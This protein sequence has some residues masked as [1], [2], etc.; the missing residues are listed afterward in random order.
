MVINNGMVVGWAGR[1]QINKDV[2]VYKVY[3]V[4]KDVTVAIFPQ[5]C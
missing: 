5:S 1:D 4:Y 2:T 3:K